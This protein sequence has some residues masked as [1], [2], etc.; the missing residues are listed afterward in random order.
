MIEIHPAIESSSVFL[1]TAGWGRKVAKAEAYRI[2]EI[3]YENGFRWIDTATN[4]PIDGNPEN[5]GRTIAWLSKFYSDFP[6]LK[7]FVKAGSATNEGSPIQLVNASYFAT[8]FDILTSQL[9][10][11]LGG[12]GIHWDN[13]NDVSDRRAIIDFFY[14]IHHEGHVVGLSGIS[15]PEIYAKSS[16]AKKLPWIIQT[17]YSPVQSKLA[18]IEVAQI[19]KNFPNAKVYGYNL[20]GGITSKGLSDQGN[21]LI[22][23]DRL[24]NGT[25]SE[26]KS[27]VLAQIISRCL[28]SNVT[29]LVIG[30]SNP[31]QCLDWCTN[32]SRFNFA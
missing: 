14:K 9:G 13:C 28:S 23:L 12:L 17:N 30:P 3:Y 4:Y 25:T 32:L 10:G 18:N 22:N 31:M 20:L 2:L 11:S 26:M 27:N 24:L 1:G 6:E 8:V 5:F 29:G 15:I 16:I 21:R 19:I 7:V